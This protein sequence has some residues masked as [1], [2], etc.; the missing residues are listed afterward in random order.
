MK[1]RAIRGV[2]QDRNVTGN[3]I[4]V[5]AV[6]HYQQLRQMEGIL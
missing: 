4:T 5:R 3:N 1:D 6:E 2:N